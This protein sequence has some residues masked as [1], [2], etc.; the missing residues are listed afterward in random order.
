M[1]LMKYKQ[2]LVGERQRK[3]KDEKKKK[4]DTCMLFVS[5]PYVLCFCK[6]LTSTLVSLLWKTIYFELSNSKLE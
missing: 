6:L 2:V 4:L 5:L 3:A 1:H